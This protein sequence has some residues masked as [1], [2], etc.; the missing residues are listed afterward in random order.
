MRGLLLVVER[1]ALFMDM[2]L[3]LA[4]QLKDEFP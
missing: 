2:I 4:T 1:F 3:A